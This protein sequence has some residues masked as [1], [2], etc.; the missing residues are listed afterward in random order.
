MQ[1]VMDCQQLIQPAAI[2]HG[3]PTVPSHARPLRPKRSVACVIHLTCQQR[4]S[5]GH[6]IPPS[7][8]QYRVR[9]CAAS[10]SACA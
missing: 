1:E 10:V 3:T 9:S 4:G 5:E 6:R 7:L 2:R 8:G